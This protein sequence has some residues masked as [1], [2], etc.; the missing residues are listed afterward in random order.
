M[1]CCHGC[2][3]INLDMNKKLVFFC[4]FSFL[5]GTL[6]YCLQKNLILLP[7]LIN[8]YLNDFLIIPIVLFICLIILRW[9][10]NDKHL[11]LSLPII[12]YLCAMYS[13]L[14]EFILPGYLERYT[15]DYIDIILYFLGG[16]CFYF[17]QTKKK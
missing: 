7:P 4:S 10:R 12:L 15:Q 6:I 16:F 14:F 11:S 8:N 13:V 17:L 1:D 9:T 3:W 5:L 2:C